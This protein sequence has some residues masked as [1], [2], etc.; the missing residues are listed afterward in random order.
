MNRRRFSVAGN[1]FIAGFCVAGQ[2]EVGGVVR[3]EV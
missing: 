1:N 3:C 2:E